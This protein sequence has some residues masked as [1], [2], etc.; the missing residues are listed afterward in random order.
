M[1]RLLWVCVLVGACGDDGG[2]GGGG[3][4]IGSE[5]P[6]EDFAD[7]Y[8]QVLCDRVFDC[9][10][11]GEGGPSSPAE[12]EAAY[13]GMLEAFFTTSLI[14]SEESGRADYRGDVFANCLRL[15]DGLSCDEFTSGSFE[16]DLEASGCAQ[17]I[18]P[19]QGVGDECAMDWECT[20][21]YCEGES[22]LF[23]EEILGVCRPL[24][25]EGEACEDACEDGFWCDFGM[26]GET[27][28][29]VQPDG[30]ECF[31]D[32]ECRSGS[33]VDSTVEGEP[34]T[35]GQGSSGLCE[36]LTS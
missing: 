5:V 4:G 9:C 30:A 17:F 19:N 12:C 34:S 8:A 2:G 11:Q 14:R 10:P 22:G 25:G 16:G 6:L 33:C 32:D 31:D 20:S 28:V 1:K 35:C 26:E 7:V 21:G 18:V 27:C 3:G 13:G 36:D 29:P 23:D 15:I 24:P